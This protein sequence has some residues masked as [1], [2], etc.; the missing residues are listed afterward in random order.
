MGRMGRYLFGILLFSSAVVVAYSRRYFGLKRREWK[1]VKFRD[2]SERRNQELFEDTG[3]SVET[4]VQP[5]GWVV[6]N[7][8]AQDEATA[9][10]LALAAEVGDTATVEALLAHGAD[11]NA[12]EQE[13][14]TALQMAAWEGDT[15]IVKALLAHGADVNARDQRSMTALQ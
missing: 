9:L 4:A 1:N 5:D 11:V 2:A 14:M 6:P 12:R 3:F 8:K 13:G 15:A 10:C 7:T